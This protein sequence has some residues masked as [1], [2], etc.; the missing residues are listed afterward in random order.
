MCISGLVLIVFIYLF[1]PHVI[2]WR[3][4][5][6][7]G[8]PNDV[9]K[10][11]CFTGKKRRLPAGS[12]QPTNVTIPTAFDQQLVPVAES[13]FALGMQTMLEGGIIRE[14][15]RYASAS[16]NSAKGQLK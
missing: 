10:Y 14:N 7:V 5:S 12:A 9:K 16:A 15:S 3:I 13:H 4:R 1:V 6:H 11:L 2:R 8:Q